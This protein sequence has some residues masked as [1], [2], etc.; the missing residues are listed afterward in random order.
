M[1]QPTPEEQLR[2]LLDE[3]V[4]DL[5]P[6]ERLA[7]IR[8]RT[9][10]TSMSTS[11][12]PWIWGAL[13]A[14]AATAAVIG[15]VAVLGGGDDDAAPGP[16]D[17]PS[18]STTSSPTSSPTSSATTSPSDTGEPTSVSVG[19]Y[20]AGDTPRGP[21]LYREF[22]KVDICP[23]ETCVIIS[24]VQAAVDGSA[25]DPDYRS[26]WPSGTTVRSADWNNDYITVDLKGADALHDRPAGMTQA[27]AELAIQQVVYTAQAA[28][29]QGRPGVQLML[30]GQRS[31][32]ILGVPT[33]EPLAEGDWSKTLSLVNLS[34]PAE[35]Q[36]Y[37]GTMHVTGVA[38]SFEATVPWQLL[39]GTTV[40]KSGS[41]TA[42]GWLEHLY[43]FA[44]DVSLKGVAPGTYT[45]VA[46]TDD[47]SGGA[48]GNGPDRDTRT[49][50]VK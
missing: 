39:R 12:R 47:P 25:A 13:G 8:S 36:H 15:G 41:F 2:R 26:D 33:S 4:G 23:S 31:D 10:E 50:I 38:S 18:V 48:E 43:P 32:Q 28:L 30:D 34:D 5:E 6:Q 20:F 22:D 40:V 24:A 17:T 42:E 9:K 16:A 1:N 35:G 27:E 7:A 21:R 14:A 37:S 46:S 49:I 45:F 19:L 44:G 11:R 29:G 3:T